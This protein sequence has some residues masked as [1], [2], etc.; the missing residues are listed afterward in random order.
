[1]YGFV[2][3]NPS[4]P[5]CDTTIERE[6]TAGPLWYR[7]VDLSCPGESMH[8][9]YVKRGT[10]PGFIVFP[11]FMSAGSPIP[12]SVNQTGEGAFEI[13][14][15]KPLADGKSTVPLEFDRNG[16]VKIQ[17]FDHGRKKERSLFGG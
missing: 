3:G 5:G 6:A 12:V 16:I 17:F 8:I 4:A 13:A 1:M 14:L 10:G 9:V 7:V 15:E 2:S 11:A